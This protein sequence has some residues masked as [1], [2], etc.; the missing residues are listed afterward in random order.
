MSKKKNNQK[1]WSLGRG[2]WVSWYLATPSRQQVI[3]VSV[4]EHEVLRTKGCSQGGTHALRTKGGT[5]VSQASRR[6][7]VTCLVSTQQAKP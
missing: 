5:R 7:A 6:Q 2:S 1:E 3:E 4:G